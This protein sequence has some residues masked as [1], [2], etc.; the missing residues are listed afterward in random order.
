MNKGI[1]MSSV[2]LFTLFHL[3]EGVVGSV[4]PGLNNVSWPDTPWNMVQHKIQHWY[5][6][7]WVSEHTNWTADDHS[8]VIKRL[9]HWENRLRW[10]DES[11]LT[12]IDAQRRRVN[13]SKTE[14]TF[15][16]LISYRSQR[17]WLWLHF[18]AIMVIRDMSS[19]ESIQSS[20]VLTIKKKCHAC[21]RPH[22]KKVSLSSFSS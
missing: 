14:L 17:R 15:P 20:P 22:K 18:S 12:L 21:L 2:F 9:K 7:L 4:P 3:R 13:S 5:C 11:L 8:K 10:V 1:T 19:L 6:H 16:G